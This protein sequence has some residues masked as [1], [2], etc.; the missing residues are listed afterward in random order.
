M[1]IGMWV[2]NTECIKRKPSNV[3]GI[4]VRLGSLNWFGQLASVTLR[5][6]QITFV[7]PIAG[8]D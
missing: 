7:S 4:G 6:P 8:I 3:T 1:S 2:V 5:P